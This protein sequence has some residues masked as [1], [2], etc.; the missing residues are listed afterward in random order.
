MN[1]LFP[2]HNNGFDSLQEDNKKEADKSG[3]EN[4]CKILY[5]DNSEKARFNKLK[6]CVE[7][8]Y[9]LNKA[10]YPSPVT[11]VQSISIK[12]QPTYNSNIIFKSNGF[13]NQIMFVQH[14]KTGEEKGGKNRRSRD[15]GEIC[16]ALL[17]THL[18]RKANMMLIVN[19]PLKSSLKRMQKQST[20][21][22]RKNLAT[23]PLMEETK[24][25]W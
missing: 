3:E 2:L 17:G 5:L 12:Y 11:A 6:K 1:F 24:K 16:I 14:R 4:I 22:N 10:E 9:V 7:N 23:I 18:Y 25:C 20:R 21:Q 19:A 8:N 15:S 13:I